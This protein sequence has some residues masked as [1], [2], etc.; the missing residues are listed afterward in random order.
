[1]GGGMAGKKTGTGGAASTSR[2]KNFTPGECIGVLTAAETHWAAYRGSRTGD[3][4]RR[5]AAALLEAFVRATPAKDRH[6][7]QTRTADSINKKIKNMRS[8]YMD[9]CQALKSTGMSTAQRED[10]LIKFGGAELYDLAREAFKTSHVS[11]QLTVREPVDLTAAAP[12]ATGETGSTTVV[13]PPT[14]GGREVRP[15]GSGNTGGD[16]VEDVE[17]E[18][19]PGSDGGSAGSDG[20]EDVESGTERAPETAPSHGGAQRTASA[21]EIAAAASPVKRAKRDTAVGLFRE[22]ITEK[23]RPAAVGEAGGTT[24]S[25]VRQALVNMINAYADKARRG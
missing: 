5:S 6:L 7:A 19:G 10:L 1:M 13:P 12:T 18:D 25:D 2:S 16:S 15:A 21:G 4:K 14:A 23:M 22:Y 17:E 8:R 24:D 11:T 3:K 20:D 9:T